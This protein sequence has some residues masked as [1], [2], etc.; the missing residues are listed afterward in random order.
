[1]RDDRTSLEDMLGDGSTIRVGGGAPITR[2]VERVG[3]DVE[4]PATRSHG[5]SWRSR[6]QGIILN[7]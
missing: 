4:G 7:P 3:F 6:S 1:M 2:V 5:F